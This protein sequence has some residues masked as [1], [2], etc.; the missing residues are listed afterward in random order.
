MSEFDAR[1]REVGP[2]DGKSERQRKLDATYIF[3]A[4]TNHPGGRPKLEQ[5]A[6][7]RDPVVSAAAR[8]QLYGPPVQ[9]NDD[10]GDDD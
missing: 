4:N 8:E 2:P 9:D 10:D 7:D 1:K 5:L 6:N 3:G